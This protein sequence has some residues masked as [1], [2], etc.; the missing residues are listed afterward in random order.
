MPD[1]SKQTSE[2]IESYLAN[3]AAE[4]F[5][6][7]VDQMRPALGVPVGARGNRPQSHFDALRKS[8][9]AEVADRELRDELEARAG[10]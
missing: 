6:S 9:G 7:V 10:R 5:T 1:F 8:E 2:Q 4:L 3:R